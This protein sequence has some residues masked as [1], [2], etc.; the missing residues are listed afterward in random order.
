M[1]LRIIGQRFAMLEM[2]AVIALLVHNFYLE[3]V[4]CL[5]D[6][7]FMM[8]IITRVAHPIRARFVPIKHL[9][10]ELNT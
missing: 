3:T 2:K 5:K 8:D 1:Y 10:S 6:L 7:R 4:D 9:Q